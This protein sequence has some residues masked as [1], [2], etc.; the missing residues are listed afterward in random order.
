VIVDS[1]WLPAV[2]L[3]ACCGC[4]ARLLKL[5]SGA[6]APAPDAA[7]AL[8]EATSECR[9]VSNLTADLAVSGSVDGQRLRGHLLAGLASPASARLEAVAPAGQPLFIFVATGGDATLLLPRDRR[10]LEHGPPAQVLESIAGVP[11]DPAEL[12][13]ALIACPASTTAAAR[14]LG[15]EWRVVPTESGDA[16]LRRD[17][18]ENRWRVVA[19]VR[20]SQNQEQWRAEYR[21]F[22]QGLPRTVH[23]VSADRRRFDLTLKL[24]QVAVNETL[25]ADVFRVVI[26]PSVDPITLDELKRAR[27]GVREN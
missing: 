8:A 21:D 7:T 27:P 6:G 24:S 25:G 17:P 5:P 22:Q 10:V 23:L 3:L 26:P 12:K 4:G 18:K 14:A 20:G 13:T 1:R 15:G 11:L 2:A 9:G 19:L 16:Y